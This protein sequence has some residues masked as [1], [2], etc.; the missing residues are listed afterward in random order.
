[1]TKHGLVGHRIRVTANFF[2]PVIANPAFALRKLTYLRRIRHA[3]LNMPDA[4]VTDYVSALRR[5]GMVIIPQFIDA[6][7]ITSMRHAV[8]DQAAFEESKE[9]ERSFFYRQAGEV[10]ALASFFE[11]PALKETARAFI[12]TEAMQLRKEICLKVVHGDILSFEQFPHMD[13]WKLRMKAFLCLEDVTEENGPTIYYKGSHRGIWRLPMEARIAG[14]YRTGA[15]GFSMPEDFYL[16]CFWPYEVQRLIEAHG[17]RETVCTGPAGT[18]LIFNGQ[19]L[20]RATPLNS[21]RRLTLS[22]YWIHGGDHT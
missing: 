14:W 11:H 5:D 21:G 22:S 16:G 7:T 12:S 20:H 2:F 18:L 9:G 19:G 6:D 15:Q 13:T 3:S 1:M 17:Y 4:S 10:S 8:P